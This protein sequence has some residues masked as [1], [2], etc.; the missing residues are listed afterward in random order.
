MRL[1][2]LLGAIAIPQLLF[3]GCSSGQTTTVCADA[4]DGGCV[5]TTTTGGGGW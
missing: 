3:L 4:G 2:I 1:F 5:T